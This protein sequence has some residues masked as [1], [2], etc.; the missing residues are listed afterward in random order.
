MDDL[1]NIAICLVTYK[2]TEEALRTIRGISENL[3]YPK[4]KRAW[5]VNDDGSPPEHMEAIRAELLGKGEQLMWAN[6]QR[7]GGGTYFCGV[8]WNAC[9]GNAH[10]YSEFV[11]WLEDDWVLEQPLEIE[12]HVRLLMEREDVGIITYRGLT[13]GS[14][15]TI[16]THGGYHYLMFL[17]TCDMAYSG[18]PHLRHAR[19]VRAYGW[20]TENHNPGDMEVNYD[21][22]FRKRTGPNIWRP[23]GDKP[24]GIFAHIGERKT[25]L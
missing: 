25:F 23:A 20:F 10:Q 22:R 13:E 24:W 6:T 2:R 21:W 19:F 8:G 11:L 15:V 4:E 1:P 16:T 9:L 14:D 18:N 5:F 12:R 3:V 17:R 7:F